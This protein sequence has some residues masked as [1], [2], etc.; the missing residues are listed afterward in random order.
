MALGNCLT[1]IKYLMFIFNFV[2]WLIGCILLSVGIWV[3]VDP[4]SFGNDA[5]GTQLKIC[6][7]LLIAI[8]SIIMIVGFL[9][10]CGA[11][12]ESQCLLATFFIILFIIFG[13]LL[14]IG[15]FLAIKP[16]KVKEGLKEG[17]EEYYKNIASK[18]EGGS[19][20][21]KEML[22]AIHRDYNCCGHTAGPADFTSFTSR[23]ENCNLQTIKLCPPE[24][25]AKNKERLERDA[26]IL[27]GVA[28]G[29]AVILLL[30]M[31]FSMMLCCA[32]RDSSI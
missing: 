24:I 13:I 4:G 6:T 2:F 19:A 29:I 11:I 31:I 23:P 12:R 32:I 22:N 27:A 10:C 26:V 17:S 9:G 5:I 25:L 15:I 18:F 1:C 16:E 3:L 7:Y 21:D 30:G 14:G 28:L 20:A 8:G